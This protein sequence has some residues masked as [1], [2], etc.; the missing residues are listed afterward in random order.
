MQIVDVVTDEGGFGD[1]FLGDVHFSNNFKMISTQVV[2]Q[3][4]IT[5]PNRKY[6]PNTRIEFFA[7]TLDVYGGTLMEANKI[8]LYANESLLIYADCII[9]ST[10]SGAC[11][12]ERDGNP[13]LYQCIDPE[14]QD[15]SV[16]YTTMLDF[17]NSQFGINGN[18][19]N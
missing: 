10:D 8:I 7:D 18:T 14:L 12:T 2:V 6:N 9:R 3:G 11:Y 19:K 15:P 4:N 5:D 13:N 17:F 16:N 1:V